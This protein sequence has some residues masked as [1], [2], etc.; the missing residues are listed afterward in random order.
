MGTG[1]VT[2]YVGTYGSKPV[3]KGAPFDSTA[4]RLPALIADC[5]SSRR[6]RPA[7]HRLDAPR[8]SEQRNLEFI[9]AKV[10]V[11]ATA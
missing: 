7:Q 1:E 11:T 9:A 10:K 6:G 8:R 2:R 5:S 3:R 4:A